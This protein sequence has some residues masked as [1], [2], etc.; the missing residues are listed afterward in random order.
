M[1]QQQSIIRVIDNSGAKT[2]KCIKV[3]K[4]K[5][6]AQIGDLIIVSITKVKN[7][8][9]KVSKLKKGSIFLA[10]I[11]GLKRAYQKKK[12]FLFLTDFNSVCLL[13]KQKKLIATRLNKA[14]FKELKKKKIFKLASLSLAGFY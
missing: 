8:P 4:K 13:N 9:N 7:Y 10:V 3:L 5:P 11:V 2:A 12:N 14:I 6:K 1:I